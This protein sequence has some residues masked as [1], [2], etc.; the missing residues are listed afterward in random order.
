[1]IVESGPNAPDFFSGWWSYV[2]K[3]LRDVFGPA[4]Q[5]PWS[6]AYCGGGSKSNCRQDL[7]KSLLAALNVTPAKLYGQGDCASDPEASCYDQNRSITASAISVPPAPFQNR[8]T[9]Q[10]TASVR[11]NLP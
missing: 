6:K 11:H 3:D 10:Q 8:P 5:G 4:P 2:S 7:R 1:M 9:F